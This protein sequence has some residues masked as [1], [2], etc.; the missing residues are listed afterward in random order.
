[1][2]RGTKLRVFERGAQVRRQTCCRPAAQNPQL[3]VLASDNEPAGRLNAHATMWIG[4]ALWIKLKR[5]G[6]RTLRASLTRLVLTS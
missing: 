3:A 6:S 4:A 2:T 5:S 1:M